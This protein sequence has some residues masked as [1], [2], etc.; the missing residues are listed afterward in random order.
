MRRL[1]F[2]DDDKTELD[3]FR[4]I[5]AGKYEY[6]TIH[7]PDESA[8]LFAMSAPDIFVSDLYLP[9]QPGIQYPR[10]RKGMR[11]RS[12]GESWL[13]VSPV[14]IHARS[15]DKARLQETMKAIG[16]AY[17]LLALQWTALGQ[18][19]GNGL[20]LLAKLQAQHRDVPFVFYSRKITPEDVIRVLRTGAADAIRKSALKDEDVLSRL[21]AAQDFYRGESAHKMRAHVFMQTSLSS[22]TS[23]RRQ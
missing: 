2:I 21:A 14:C 17:A 6:I 19:P 9:L 1:V 4:G 16:D 13:S 5:V 20:A 7:W 15:T 11:L 12:T 22:R 8:R 18:S 3:T 23:N 10:R